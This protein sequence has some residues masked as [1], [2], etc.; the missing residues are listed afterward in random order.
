MGTATLLS[1]TVL[2][3]KNII[4]VTRSPASLWHEI[5]FCLYWKEE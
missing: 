4:L 1:A 3:D 2:A 5:T